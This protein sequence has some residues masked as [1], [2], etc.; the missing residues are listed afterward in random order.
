MTRT[1]VQEAMVITT[2]KIL[3]SLLLLAIGIAAVQA[4]DEAEAPAP[5]TTAYVSLGDPM[6]LNLSGKRKLTFLQISAD[7]LVRDSDTEEA[8]KIHV[9]AIRHSLI[10]LLSEQ[11]AADIKSPGKREE[12]RQ[13]AT[14]NVKRLITDLSGE[15]EVAEVLFSNILVQ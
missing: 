11:K 13:V 7:V 14:A 8:V 10:M 3:L 1:I 6:V 15:G 2:Q 4:S 9:P 5:G 12:I